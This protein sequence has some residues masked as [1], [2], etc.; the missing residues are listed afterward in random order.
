MRLA[1]DDHAFV[2]EGYYAFTHSELFMVHLVLY[3]CELS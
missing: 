2:G 1:K 3:A